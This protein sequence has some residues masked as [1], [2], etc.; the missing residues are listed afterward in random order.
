MQKSLLAT[1]KTQQPHLT[2]LGATHLNCDVDDVV[3]DQHNKIVTTPAYML[4]QS[5]IEA[6]AGIEK[7][8]KSVLAL[9]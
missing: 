1:I 7:L 3:I 8:V 9:N 2:K 4:A 5:I 6:D